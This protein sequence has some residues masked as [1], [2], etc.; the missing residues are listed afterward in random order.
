LNKIGRMLSVAAQFNLFKKRNLIKVGHRITHKCNYECSYCSVWNDKIKELDTEQILRLVDEIADMGCVAYAVTGGEP[1]VRKDL[2][3]ILKRIKE[4]GMLAKLV[5]NGALVTKRLDE[6]YKNVDVLSFSFDT[7]SPN[8]PEEMGFIKVL[9]DK[10]I[11][12]IKAA[13]ERIPHVGF[14]LIISKLTLKELDEIVPYCTSLGM[15]SFTFSPLLTH[16]NYKSPEDIE[17]R[18]DELYGGIENYKKTILKLRELRDKGYPVMM[19]DLLLETM[20]TFKVPKL[21]CIS[22]YLSCSVSPDGRLGPCFEFSK[23]LT[24]SYHNKSFKE[25]WE[26]LGTKASFVDNCPGCFLHCYFETNAMFSGNLKAIMS[27]GAYRKRYLKAL[28]SK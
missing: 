3:Q 5:T 15:K 7:I 23:D 12:G 10:I 21:K 13:V 14:N 22:I 17:K 8:V 9:D 20:Y 6:I 2:P 26:E 24:D 16:F 28:L 11:E 27:R 18:Y 4:R 1:L 19:S 25:L